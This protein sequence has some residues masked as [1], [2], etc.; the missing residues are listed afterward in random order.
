[1]RVVKGGIYRVNPQKMIAA[2]YEPILETCMIAA[3]R[4]EFEAKE[5]LRERMLDEKSSGTLE[6]SIIGITDIKPN[7][8][9]IALM[10]SAV[11]T[12]QWE[13]MQD[14]PEEADKARGKG[15][16]DYALAVELGTGEF[17][18]DEYGTVVGEP[19]RQTPISFS[20]WGNIQTRETD[21]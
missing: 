7:A 13:E 11:E 20:G 10:A 3:K 18:E 19:I 4:A 6:E 9:I 1:M 16:F 2:F 17:R 15:N 8:I 5:L 12:G 14:E 21:R